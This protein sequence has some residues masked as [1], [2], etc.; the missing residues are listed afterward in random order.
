MELNSQEGSEEKGEERWCMGGK[1]LGS[2]LQ[3]MFSVTVI[4]PY[5]GLNSTWRGELN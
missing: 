1:H 5:S 2:S 4:S 3:D